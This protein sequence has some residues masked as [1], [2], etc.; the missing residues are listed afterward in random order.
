MVGLLSSN[1]SKR[2]RSLFGFG[3]TAPAITL[4]LRKANEEHLVDRL[5]F[6]FSWLMCDCFQPWS[7]G[8]TNQ[9]ILEQNVDA[10]IGPPCV[11][12]ALVA[13]YGATFYNIPMFLW[14]PTVSSDLNNDTLYPTVFNT[15]VNSRMLAMAVRSILGNYNWSE[16]SF[17]YT[18]DDQRMVCQYFYTDFIAL[19]NDDPNVTI[20][21]RRKMDSSAE[22]MRSTLITVSNRSRIV[23]SCFDNINDRRQFLL[24]VTDLGLA[25]KN[26]EYVFITGS[27][28]GLGMTQPGE[29]L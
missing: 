26:T 18:P 2:L 20:V 17:V 11:T 14:G 5:N 3:Q 12:S 25:G 28:R 10:L 9:L 8:Y 21:Y 1:G 6:T 16:V 29:K 24:A 13:G 15:N 27:M 23:I 22:S 7:I 4:A 19:V